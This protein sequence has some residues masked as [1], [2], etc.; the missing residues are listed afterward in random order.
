MAPVD[1]FYSYAHEDE[2]LRD[3]LSVHLKILERRGVI[4]SWH[5]RA[6]RP[7]QSWDAEISEQLATADL[8]LLLVSADFINSDY[9]WSNE[10]AVAMQRH[11]RGEAS[12]VP[13]LVRP[14][15]ID[16]APF[17][18]LQGLPTDLRAVMSWPNRGRGLDQR[19]HR[20]P[21]GRGRHPGRPGAFGCSGPGGSAR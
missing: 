20:H 5:D 19:G 2:P 1:L 21:Q 8:L 7:G 14:C 12:V 3:E 17:A 10:L 9:I 11:Q 4:R 13:V 18:A 16:D 15:L 6:I